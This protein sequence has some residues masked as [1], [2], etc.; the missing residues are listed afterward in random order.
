MV[1]RLPVPSGWRS[2]AERRQRS[3][4]GATQRPRAPRRR[5]SSRA[6]SPTSPADR[7][8]PPARAGAPSARSPRSAAWPSAE[9]RLHRVAP[10]T[11]TSTRSAP[12]DA[13]VDVVGTCAA[14]ELLDVDE[15]QLEPSP[16]ASGWCGART[17][18][19]AEPGAGCG[20]AAP[21][22]RPDLRRRHRRSSSRRPPARPCWPRLATG[23]GP[24]PAM[25]LEAVG[26]GA[27]RRDL[28]GRPNVTQVV[29]GEAPTGAT[30]SAAPASP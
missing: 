5:P 12:L 20:R 8:G 25:T 11:S 16:W 29:I 24:L 1:A 4:I 22:R 27:G 30:R 3:G 9:G 18:L 6:P 2:S 17:R 23:W 10:S 26:F 21:A 28:D 7:G 14:L 15:V 19:A 13:I